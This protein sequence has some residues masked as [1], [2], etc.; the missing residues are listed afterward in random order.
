[1]LNFD[2]QP[3]D[4][5]VGYRLGWEFA[6]YAL[7]PPAGPASD[8]PVHHGWQAGRAC[9]AQRTLAPTIHVQ[10][11]LGLRLCAW[12]S[13]RAFEDVLVTPNHLRQID[14]PWCPITRARLVSHRG[15]AE[16]ASIDRVRDDAGYAAGNLVLMSRRANAAKGHCD[17]D[18]AL[19]RMRKAEADPCAGDLDAAQ[20]ERV[21]VLCSFVTAMAHV[22]AALL[23]LAVLPPNRLRLF[24]P[25]QALQALVTRQFESPGWSARTAR[26]EALLEQADL[27]RDFQRFV[28][29]LLPRVLESGRHEDAYAMRWALEDAWR[30]PRVRRAWSRFALPLSAPQAERIVAQAGALGLGPRTQ[31]LTFAQ[32]TEGW[33]IERSGRAS[34]ESRFARVPKPR[35]EAHPP[36]R[37]PSP[38]IAQHAFWSTASS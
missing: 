30:C 20:W 32:A 27:R 18:G 4:T 2:A 9:F 37:A 10:H 13:G 29:A 19:A 33:A 1:M 38:V 36:L 5:A 21:A 24:N 17:F 12:R 3:A 26:I 7:T 11:W 14:V 23:P 6:H 31:V 25:I 15:S 28:H 16:E 22:Q 35:R 34:F 8:A